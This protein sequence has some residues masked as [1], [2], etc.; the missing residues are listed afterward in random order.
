[1]NIIIKSLTFLLFF[2]FSLKEESI[3]IL[4]Y[5]DNKRLLKNLWQIYKTKYGIICLI[6]LLFLIFLNFF[7]NRE[8]T[9]FIS[10]TI[11]FIYILL[12]PSLKFKYTRRSISIMIIISLFLS[13]IFFLPLKMIN[14]TLLSIPFLS[15]I[16]VILCN[17]FE[18]I[19]ELIIRKK[20]IKKAKI[21]LK[22]NK[23]RLIIA[24]TGS[25]GKTSLKYYLSQILSY[26]FKV[27]AS[28]GSV[29]TLM[30]L[31]KFINNEIEDYDEII[32]LEAGVDSLK[33]MDKL[34]TLFTPDIGVLTSVGAM[35]L[36]TFK[37]KDNI[38]FEKRKLLSASKEGYYCLDND[39]LY[40]KK[41]DLNEFYNYSMNEY[42]SSIKRNENGLFV[43][44]KE[45]EILIPLYGIFTL[46]S[47]SVVIKIALTLGFTEDEIISILPNLKGE[48][49]RLEKRI[50]NNM[51]V[52]DDAYNGNYEGIKEGIKTLLCFKGKKAIITP[53]VI[54][55]GK[56]YYNINYLLGKELI[57]LDLI[58]IVSSSYEHPLKDGYITNN[59]NINKLI[60]VNNFHKGYE[61][62]KSN[63]I[64]ALLI[65]NDTF[66]T[67]IK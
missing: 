43:T 9:F 16:C 14:Y 1:M 38:F 62:V 21:K 64:N 6:S 51:I 32:I 33:G 50:V 28:K 18:F 39:Y 55:L 25:Y 60:I 42:F 31:T 41:D 23:N 58:I 46:S 19:F 34:L 4:Q 35:H 67:F 54:E 11:L 8:L 53:G 10:F 63:N 7:I 40:Q 26:K 47:L 22:N 56:D 61:I 5:Y 36:A 2:F 30:G 65:A 59:G 45:K 24:I 3:L 12:F 17:H 29:N 66:K 20:Y 27:R 13:F 48:K 15:I 49:H 57:N 44:F 37:N 52:L